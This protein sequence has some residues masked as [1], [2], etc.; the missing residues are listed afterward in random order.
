MHEEFWI[1]VIFR[2]E[3]DAEIIVAGAEDD[4]AIHQGGGEI[5][6]ASE[7]GVEGLRHCS[8]PVFGRG[9]S[10]RDRRPY[11][12]PVAAITAK[13]KAK[14]PHARVVDPLRVDGVRPVAG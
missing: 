2:G 4:N 13:T 11:V 6:S 12:R 3:H 8:A 14:R 10:P 7:S 5:P 1:A 9:P